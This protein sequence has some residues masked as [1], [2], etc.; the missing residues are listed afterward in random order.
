MKV[1]IIDTFHCSEKLPVN[2]DTAL[3]FT[4]F[5]AGYTN[6]NNIL[7]NKSFSLLLKFFHD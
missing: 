1:P 2:F 6:G 3:A 5:C 4:T 7:F